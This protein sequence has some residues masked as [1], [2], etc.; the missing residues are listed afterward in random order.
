MD[1]VRAF[2]SMTDWW[3]WAATGL[4]VVL[5][6]L[7]VKVAWTFNVNE[8]MK[9]RHERRKERLQVLCPH[10]WLSLRENPETGKPDWY[11][12]SLVHSAP[13]TIEGWC[14][15]CGMR[16]NDW[17][18]SRRF[19]EQYGNDPKYWKKRQMKYQKAARRTFKV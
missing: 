7:S 11:I 13:G 18:E 15:Q 2:Q 16:F 6:G 14:S 3:H 5:A 4:T 8:W 9:T 1:R 17:T 19:S 12:Q 10:T